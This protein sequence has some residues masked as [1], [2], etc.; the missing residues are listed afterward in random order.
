M[1]EFRIISIGTLPAH[2][3][4]NERGDVRTGHATSTLISAVD[5]HIIVNPALPPQAFAARLAERSSIRLDQ[6]THVFLTSFDRSHRRAL[7]VLEHARW[8][9]SEAERDAATAS[10]SHEL[11]D[12]SDD[13]SLAAMLRQDAATLERL[14]IAPDSLARGVDLF[15]LPGVTPGTC[16]LLL[17]L[18]RLTALVCGDAIP[19]IEHLQQGKVMPN[20]A[21]IEQAQESFKEAI[22]IGDVIILG[23]DNWALNPLRTR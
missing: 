20:C 11:A 23:R 8:L 14:E 2:P 13:P 9:I 19:T 4:W 3:L 12:A 21:N 17:P 16:G 5:M 10:L 7:P 18:P 1:I 22:E 15:P 6:L